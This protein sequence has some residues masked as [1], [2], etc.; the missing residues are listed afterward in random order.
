V[1]SFPRDQLPALF[2]PREESEH[3]EP[4]RVVMS[5]SGASSVSLWGEQ[6]LRYGLSLK[7]RLS[8]LWG[9]IDSTYAISVL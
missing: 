7:E 2:A 1:F 4:L 3:V 8:G 5:L 9:R 6:E